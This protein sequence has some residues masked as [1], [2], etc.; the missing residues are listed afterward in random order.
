MGKDLYDTYPAARKVFD[1]ASE[2]LEFD[3]RSICFEGPVERI[4]QTRFAQPAIFVASMAALEVLRSHAKNAQFTPRFAAGLSLGEAT[5]LCASGAI[6]FED[7]VRFVKA[8]GLF[9][10]EAAGEKPGMMA[11]V[12]GSPLAD[13]E[14]ICAATGAE[15][16]NLNAPGQIVISGQKKLV[17]DAVEKLREAGARVIPLEVSGGFHSSCMEPACRRIGKA[18]E[19]VTIRKPAIPVVSNLTANV[20]N[21][22]AK[23][24]QNLIW[25]MNHR[26]LWEDSMRFIL[27]KGVKT[28]IE[29]SPGK[30][31]KGLLRKIDPSAET[32]SLNALEDFHALESQAAAK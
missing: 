8:R 32:L 15:V 4:T 10:D 25:Q 5:A 9:M 22:P 29:F 20:E 3:I 17:E 2:L 21:D 24:K 7:G 6:S 19:H 12:L 14:K 26:T 27:G 28:F 1:R 11:A 31:L 16:G 18:L 30:V 13:V 23:I